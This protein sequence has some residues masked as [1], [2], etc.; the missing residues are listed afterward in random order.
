[1]QGPEPASISGAGRQGDID[2]RTIRVRAARLCRPA[3]AGEQRG[4]ML[5]QADRQHPR[6]VPER[7][8]HTVTVMHVDVDVRD[9]LGALLEQPGNRDRRVV[10]DAEAAGVAAH[11]MVQAA[12]NAGTVLGSTGPD[13][14]DRGQRR[15]GDERGRLVH[16][17]EDRVVRSA[18][19][20]LQQRRR[21]DPRNV[22]AG[23]ERTRAL[24]HGDVLGV[25]NE[26]QL[27]VRG[28]RRRRHRDAVASQ[29]PEC[30]CQ[31]HR[32]LDPDGRQRVLGS[33]IVTSQPFVPGHVQRTRHA[34]DPSDVV[35]L[36]CHIA[37]SCPRPPQVPARLTQRMFAS[38]TEQDEEADPEE[39][40]WPSPTSL[41]SSPTRS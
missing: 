16:P 27:G 10:V 6:V 41:R 17:G 37:R 28:W 9:S 3:R 11:G 35:R 25:V 18:E 20:V 5:V 33:E 31:L 15:A 14:T 13:G 1:M 26:R 38:Y 4:R 39:E 12:S 23:R 32:E 36:A 40:R 21:V 2:S 19:P 30:L 29:Q 34:S 8:L 7:G 22:A 24:H